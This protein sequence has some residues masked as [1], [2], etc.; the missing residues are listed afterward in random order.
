VVVH[1]AVIE[2]FRSRY[3]NTHLC[4]VGFRSVLNQ[5]VSNA[6]GFVHSANEWCP[7][8]DVVDWTYN[9]CPVVVG[10][11]FGGKESEYYI[12]QFGPPH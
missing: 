11:L 3:R 1:T 5:D 2:G 6:L 8:V 9:T 10:S 12:L 4:I 7:D